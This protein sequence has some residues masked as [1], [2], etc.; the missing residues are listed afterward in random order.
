MAERFG[1]GWADS[2]RE[3]SRN[4]TSWGSTGFAE[5]LFAVLAAVLLAAWH[6]Q[7]W[8]HFQDTLQ[9]QVEQGRNVLT[10]TAQNRD[11]TSFLID[12]ASCQALQQDEGVVRAGAV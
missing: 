11:E 10:F 6:V 8:T 9:S 7:Q 3:G 5:L 2:A 1:W 4:L 12:V